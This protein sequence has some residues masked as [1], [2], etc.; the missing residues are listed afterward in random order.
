MTFLV[1]HAALDRRVGAEDVADGLAQ[2]LGAVD[3]HE[4]ALLDVKAALDQIREQG[5]GDSGVLG[6]AVP[7]PEWVLD[8]VGVD[9]ERDDAAATLELDPV[10]HHDRQ[11]QILQ[12]AAHQ[13][14]QLLAR[15]RDE[16]ARDRRLAL[17]ARDVV[18]LAAD[19]LARARVVAR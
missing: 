17:R 12:R 13:I 4:H 19:R 15:T 7:Q 5:G 1:A 18:D 8:A 14:D 11:T 3:D 9:A 6:R 10:E 2:R 16:L